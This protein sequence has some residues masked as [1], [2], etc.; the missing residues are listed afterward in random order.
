M[1]E[2]QQVVVNGGGEPR[3]PIAQRVPIPLKEAPSPVL[4]VDERTVL[5]M[6]SSEAEALA[7]KLLK[8]RTKL[9]K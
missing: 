2:R 9:R 3:P 6:S 7:Q 4:A 1:A 5:A 8:V